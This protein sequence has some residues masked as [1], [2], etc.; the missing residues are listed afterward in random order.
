[1]EQYEVAIIG[2]GVA[3]LTAALYLGRFERKTLLLTESFGG[4]TAIAGVVENYPGIGKVAGAQLIQQTKEQVS[5]LGSV[6]LKEGERVQKIAK[7]KEGFV[8]T[9]AKEYQA[10]SIIIATGRRHRELGLPEEKGL[11]G[12]GLSYCATCDGPFARNKAVVVAGGG[13]AANRAAL[14]LQKIA[15]KIFI[16]NLAPTLLGEKV[17]IE[18]IQSDSKFT[19]INN[20][21]IVKIAV[22]EGAIAGV[23]V[24]ETLS[25]K[26]R[27]IDCQMIFVEIGQVANSE[28]FRNFVKL[29][30]QGEIVISQDCQASIPGAFAA[31]DVTD[32]PAKQIVVAAGEGAKAAIAINKFLIS[33]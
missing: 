30:E 12:K 27:Q 31:G 18:K 24:E 28:P 19:V 22:N 3:G 2:G 6:R 8:V 23:E 17:S 11:I 20:A 5:P 13:N 16:V 25:K 21:K 4:Q 14:T 1:M 9:S 7:D 15:S 29:N 10:K 32:I 33:N 26:R